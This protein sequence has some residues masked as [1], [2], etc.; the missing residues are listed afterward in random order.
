MFLFIFF[1]KKIGSGVDTD[2]LGN[3]LQRGRRYSRD[4]GSSVNT[5][6]LGNQFRCGYHFSRNLV[7]VWM[8]IFQEFSS[9]MDTDIPG[10]QFR[11]SVPAWIPIFQ[12]FFGFSL[13]ERFSGSLWIRLLLGQ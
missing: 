11:K 1:A 12:V 8:L 7:P 4:I 10:I 3:Q 13:N 2:I 9:G 6:S 5:I